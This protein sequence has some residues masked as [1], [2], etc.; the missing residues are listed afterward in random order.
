MGGKID[1]FFNAITKIGVD[2]STLKS[3][4]EKYMECVD[5]LDAVQCIHYM[6]ISSKVQSERLAIVAS[7]MMDALNFEGV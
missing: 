1:E 4:I 2:P 3:E 6:K 5:H 7:Q